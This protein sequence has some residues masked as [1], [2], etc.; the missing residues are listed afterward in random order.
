MGAREELASSRLL[1]Q[2]R[3]KPKVRG[4]E[5]CQCG[6]GE[7]ITTGAAR[8]YQAGTDYV[9]RTGSSERRGNHREVTGLGSPPSC[10][11]PCFWAIRAKARDLPM[12]G[13]APC[14]AIL[15]R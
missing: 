7:G 4:P 2:E 1:K 3:V 14:R 6:I 15:S 13:L 9:G 12:L 10:D 5:V 8:D 11:L